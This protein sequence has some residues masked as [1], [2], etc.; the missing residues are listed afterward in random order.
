MSRLPRFTRISPTFSCRLTRNIDWL[1]FWPNFRP[2][3]FVKRNMSIPGEQ[4]P[5]KLELWREYRQ[6]FQEFAQAV[7]EVQSLKECANPSQAA[8]EAALL[9]RE[10]AYARYENC[11]DALAA[12][13]LSDSSR[14]LAARQAF[15]LPHEN[16][17]RV[18]EIA[19]SPWELENR[20]EG[21]A[22]DDWFRGEDIL[23]RA[24]EGRSVAVAAGLSPR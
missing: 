2:V 8:I 6:A 19:E 1:T 5:D 9:D 23:R 12:A 20:P 14:G 11:R 18:K 15:T 3:D 22:D 10:K 16:I 24:L 7:D 4:T 17:E 21:K 13:L